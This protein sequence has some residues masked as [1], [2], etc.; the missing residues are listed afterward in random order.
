MVI[1]DKSSKGL[2]KKHRKGFPGDLAANL[3]DRYSE[4]P[5]LY[6]VATNK[7]TPEWSECSKDPALTT[8]ISGRLS[9]RCDRL[10]MS[11]KSSRLEIKPHFG[12]KECKK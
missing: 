9:F 6:M 10:R 2:E 8:A 5:W 4:A 7:G 3:K 12:R 11:G 1:N